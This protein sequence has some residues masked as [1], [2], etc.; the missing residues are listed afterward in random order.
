MNQIIPGKT[1]A[2]RTQIKLIVI[3][4]LSLVLLI[5]IVMVE[6]IISERKQRR[7]VAVA[8]ITSTWGSPQSVVGPV[9]IVP[10]RYYFKTEKDENVDGKIVRREVVQSAVDNAYFLPADLNIDGVISP[11]RLHRGIYEAVVYSGSVKI[12]GQFPSLDWKT[13]KIDPKEALWNDAVLT[14]AIPDLRGAKGALAVQLGGRPFVMLPGSKIPGYASGAHVAV[15][16][17]APG[18]PLDF[19]LA[20]DLNGSSNIQ[21]APLGIRNIVS[22]Q[23]AW[24]NPKF[25][26]SFLPV[27]RNLA[28]DGFTAKWD[29]SYYGRNYPQSAT[30]RGG[31]KPEAE[32]INSSLFGV[33]FLSSIDSYR[34]VERSTK[35][36]IL[37]IAMVFIAF[38]LFEVLASL[39]IH[40]VQYVL[41]GLA[42][43][44]FFL[45]LLSLSEFLPFWASYLAAAAA[46]TA[47]IVSYSAKF[48]GSGRR[49]AILASELAAVYGYL[50]V[51]LQLQDFSL[52]MGCG[53]LVGGL[54][55]LMYLTR[56]VNWYEIDDQ[57][58]G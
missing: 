3:A 23:S 10:Y 38:F 57:G 2:N 7:D 46:A 30:E 11:K 20:I 55:A 37:F 4:A 48:L 54:G 50:Y 17:P 9:L 21:F 24:A 44:L 8:D 39:Q 35:Y 58:A 49:T 26:G 27:D 18:R 12:S 6:S 51:V 1:G 22:L 41:V 15:G 43:A 28:K 53:L 56:N 16:E 42:L 13:L 34:N 25:Q 33:E 19:S 52:L 47:M 36:G 45:M 32:A 14:V 40:V 31:G 29:V 5:P